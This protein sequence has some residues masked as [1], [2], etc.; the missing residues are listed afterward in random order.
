MAEPHEI[1]GVSPNATPE[2]VRAAYKV[3]ARIYH[4]DRFQGDTA[5]VQAEAGRRMAELNSAYEAALA[6]ASMDVVYETE[7]W[8]N[9]QRLELGAE[10][11]AAGVPYEWEGS[12]LRVSRRYEEVVDRIID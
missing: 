7:R 1:L 12:D 11:D 4:P 5:T 3:L 10:L 8:T 2:E 9:R 6:L